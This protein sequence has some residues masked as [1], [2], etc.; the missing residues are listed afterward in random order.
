MPIIT[1]EK[2]FESDIAASFLSP[3]GGYTH[4]DD[5]YESPEAEYHLTL[6]SGNTVQ[7][8]FT[9]MPEIHSISFSQFCLLLRL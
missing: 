5:C 6:S 3:A 8:F 2:Q 1:T 7:A 9:T 4:N